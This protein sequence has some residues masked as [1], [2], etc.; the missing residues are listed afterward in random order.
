M[1]YFN[2]SKLN[3]KKD[4]SKYDKETI[5]LYLSYYP[6]LTLLYDF[7]FTT[8]FIY[9]YYDD[10]NYQ[11]KSDNIS[12]VYEKSMITYNCIKKLHIISIL[13]HLNMCYNLIKLM[14]VQHL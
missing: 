1:L 4:F 14:I 5:D 12:E 3:G 2:I 10:T 13:I 6:E 8:D 9:Y 11:I 7:S